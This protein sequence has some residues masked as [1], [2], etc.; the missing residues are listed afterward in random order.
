M[1][2]IIHRRSLLYPLRSFVEVGYGDDVRRHAEA[3]ALRMGF[4]PVKV[5]VVAEESED[6]LELDTPKDH[7]PKASLYNDWRFRLRLAQITLCHFLRV[8]VDFPA[9]RILNLK[10]WKKTIRITAPKFPKDPSKALHRN[11]VS[12]GGTILKGGLGWMDKKAAINVYARVGACSV[13]LIH[14][15][16]G[17]NIE[18]LRHISTMRITNEEEG[19]LCQ[20][21]ERIRSSI[22]KTR[23]TK[24][25]KR[26]GTMT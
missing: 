26:S 2:E 13:H 5:E 18:D 6:G 19:I 23:W 1:I 24:A 12:K 16:P 25:R 15:A 17:R 21:A 3:H 11:T 20:E 22:A 8:R 14:W 4:R 10:L 7:G 9:N